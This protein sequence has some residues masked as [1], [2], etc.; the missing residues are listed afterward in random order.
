MY[1]MFTFY[2]LLKVY[3]YNIYKASVIPGSLQQIMP[4]L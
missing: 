2:M 4:Y 1:T 3:V